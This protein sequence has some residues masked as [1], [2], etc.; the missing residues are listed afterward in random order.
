MLSIVFNK[1]DK[2]FNDQVYKEI[3]KNK[4]SWTKDLINVK[5]LTSGFNPNLG[6]FKQISDEIAEYLKKDTGNDYYPIRWWANYYKKGDHTEKHNHVPEDVSVIVIIKASK[7]NVLTFYNHSNNT[8]K[9]S[10]EDG[11]TLIFPS[12]TYHSV[13]KCDGRRVSLAIDFKLTDP[14]KDKNG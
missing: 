3:L 9:V 4:K 2:K 8:F 1:L 10:E 6:F 14:L 11:L 13:D 12:T 5:S 7:E